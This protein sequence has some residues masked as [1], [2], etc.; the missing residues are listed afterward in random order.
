MEVDQLNKKISELKNLGLVS[1]K[2]LNEI[3]IY[4]ETDLID[5]GICEAY[6]VMKSK[7]RTSLNFLYAMYAAIN[8]IHWR[9]VTTDIK[10]E[11]QR[12]VN[13]LS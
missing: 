3:G 1:Q 7:Q 8:D 4:T 10:E 6:A 9:N 13:A 5:F 11:L 2:S 12:N